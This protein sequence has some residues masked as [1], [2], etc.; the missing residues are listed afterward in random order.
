MDGWPP[1]QHMD[2]RLYMVLVW[3]SLPRAIPPPV[4][5]CKIIENLGEKRHL[6]WVQSHGRSRLFAQTLN[7]ISNQGVRRESHT[8]SLW[9]SL[10]SSVN[11]VRIAGIL[12]CLNVM[13]V[14]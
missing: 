7:L 3:H 12:H 13:G 6:L 5:R 1:I 10:F 2:Q 4:Q 11:F 9:I 14:F 8:I